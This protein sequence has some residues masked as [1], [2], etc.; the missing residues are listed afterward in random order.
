MLHLVEGRPE[1]QA[2]PKEKKIKTRKVGAAGMSAKPVV[3]DAANESSLD[4]WIQIGKGREGERQRQGE[5]ERQ[6]DG[7]GSVEFVLRQSPLISLQKHTFR[8]YYSFIIYLYSICY[9][10]IDELSC[11]LL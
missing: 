11:V 2:Q 4:Y 6:S 1:A 3:D 7:E 9:R 10:L 8:H 5:G